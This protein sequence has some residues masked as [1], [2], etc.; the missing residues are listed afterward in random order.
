MQLKIVSPGVIAS[1]ELPSLGVG[2]QKHPLQKDLSFVLNN[3]LEVM[4]CASF[5]QLQ[6]TPFW[7]S[8]LLSM[9]ISAA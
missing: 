3:T 7:I 2:H 8:V 1:K 9:K 6:L 4:M 5:L